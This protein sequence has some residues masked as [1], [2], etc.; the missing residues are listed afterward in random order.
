MP[1]GYAR[2]AVHWR[3]LSSSPPAWR[4][5]HRASPV[6]A[7]RRSSRMPRRRRPQSRRTD[8]SACTRTA[9]RNSASPSGPRSLRASAHATATA[10]A[11]LDGLGLLHR[12]DL[13]LHGEANDLDLRLAVGS[14]LHLDLAV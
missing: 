3:S 9:A 10:T 14:L 2:S 6:P 4:A 13:R 7:V 12:H 11:T 8:R 5:A 1:A